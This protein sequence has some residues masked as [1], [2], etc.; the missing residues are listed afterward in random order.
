MARALGPMQTTRGIPSSP[1]Q[2]F[3]FASGG[4]RYIHGVCEVSMSDHRIAHSSH[5][6]IPVRRW[7]R[8]MSA[9]FG[10]MAVIVFSI[11]ASSIARTGARSGAEVRPRFMPLTCVSSALT[12]AGI[13]ASSS[14]HSIICLVYH[15]RR[16]TDDRQIPERTSASRRASMSACVS[17]ASIAWP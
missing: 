10:I 2:E 17:S 12:T 16:L 6:R 14:A 13:I 11:V 3:L 1:R 5:G 15:R 8:T 7:T 4:T 9:V